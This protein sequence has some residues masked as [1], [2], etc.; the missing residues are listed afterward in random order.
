MRSAS[1]AGACAE[2]EV[3][4]RTSSNESRNHV[5]MTPSSLRFNSGAACGNRAWR[6]F[7]GARPVR[8]AQGET[9]TRSV[10]SSTQL[11]ITLI[12]RAGAMSASLTIRNRPSGAMS[13]CRPASAMKYWSSKSTGAGAQ[14]HDGL[15]TG[16]LYGKRSCLAVERGDDV[17]LAGVA[18]HDLARAGHPDHHAI[19]ACQ[20]RQWVRLDAC[21]GR[22]TAAGM[23]RPDTHARPGHR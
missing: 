6:I 14:G 8:L 21:A 5:R 20:T 16:R 23:R 4:A 7:V 1:S 3:V 10:S 17:G 22:V 9:A 11:R 19:T 12:C 15:E 18:D 2:A 13:K